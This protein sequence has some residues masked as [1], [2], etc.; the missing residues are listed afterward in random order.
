MLG[1]VSVQQ[2]LLLKICIELVL[3]WLEAMWQEVPLCTS[4]E[5]AT[6][7]LLNMK[8]HKIK[9]S[10]FHFWLQNVI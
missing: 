8:E 7:R 6:R 3:F 10:F 2:V 9:L 5:F 1:T 4:H